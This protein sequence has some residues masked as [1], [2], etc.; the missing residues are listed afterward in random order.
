MKHVVA[1]IDGS[2]STNAVGQYASW[3]ARRLRCPLNLL[4]VLDEDRF[5]VQLNLTASPESESQISLLEEMARLDKQR[6]QLA[7]QHGQNLLAAA[8][9]A[10]YQQGVDAVQRQQRHG[11]PVASLTEVEEQMRLLV[12]SLHNMNSASADPIGSPLE[13]VVRTIQKPI[14]VTP[15]S[16]RQPTSVMLAFD[17]SDTARKGVKMLAESPIFKGMPIDLVMVDTDTPHARASIEAA[18]NHLREYR[19][20]VNFEIRFGDI[21]STLSAYQQEKQ[22][23]L[24]VMG[25]YGQ[26]RGRN[27]FI[28]STTSKMLHKATTPLL[29]LR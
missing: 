25:A 11:D 16:F 18:A 15:K 1:A 8:E 23:D 3:A 5:P 7:L 17:G 12:I 2:I 24:L 14:L 22:I 21:E 27:F 19:H 13:T 10:A 9:S 28:G 29:L 4:H 26:S 6:N 20:S